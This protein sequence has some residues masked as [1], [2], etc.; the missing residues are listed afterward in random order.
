MLFG[1]I[2]ASIQ[3][4]PKLK[5]VSYERKVEKFERLASEI[6]GLV[7]VTIL[8]PLLAIRELYLLLSRGGTRRLAASIFQ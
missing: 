1:I 3:K 8:T 6:E 2:C 4:R 7:A 5:L